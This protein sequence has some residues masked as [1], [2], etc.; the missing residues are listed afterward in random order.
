MVS[1]TKLTQTKRKNRDAKILKKRHKK[2]RSAIKK[3]K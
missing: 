2:V 3:K 1:P